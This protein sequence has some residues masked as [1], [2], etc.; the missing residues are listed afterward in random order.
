[1]TDDDETWQVYVHKL[2][3]WV[4]SATPTSTPTDEDAPEPIPTRPYLIL[5]VSAKDGAF[6]SHEHDENERGNVYVDE[7][8]CEDVVDFVAKTIAA[9]RVLNSSRAMT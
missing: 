8:T 4:P 9:P 3:A 2:R 7:P 5:I 1:M 6:L